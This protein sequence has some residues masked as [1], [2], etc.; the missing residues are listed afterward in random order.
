MKKLFALILA[1]TIIMQTISISVTAANCKAVTDTSATPDSATTCS[2]EAEIPGNFVIR[3]TKDLTLTYNDV[4]NINE[5][6][7]GYAIAQLYNDKVTSYKVKSGVST[8]SKDSAVFKQESDTEFIT[9]ATGNGRILLVKQATVSTAKKILNGQSN[10]K[11]NAIVLNITVNP[12]PL[13]IVYFAGQSNSEGS[14]SANLSYHPEDSVM[15]KLGEVYSTY[16]PSNDSRAQKITG[17]ENF[18]VCTKDKAQDYVTGSLNVLED[19]SISSKPLTYSLHSLTYSGNGKTGPD[20]GFAYKYNT[21]TGDKVW[22]VNAAWGGSSVKQ[23]VK[24][25]EAYNRAMAVYKEA[26]KTYNAEISAGHFTQSKRLCIWVQGEADKNESTS[27]YREKFTNASSNLISEL[28]LDKLGIIIVRSAIDKQYKNYRDNSLSAPRVVQTAMGNDKTLNKIHLVSRTHELWVTDDNVKNYFDSKYPSGTLN[29]P[30]RSNSTILH[31]P[32]TVAAIHYDIHFSQAGHN[33]NGIDAAENMYHILQNETHDVDITWLKEDGAFV[34][35]NAIDANLNIDFKLCARITPESQSKR[36]TISTD[37]NYLKYNKDTLTFTPIKSGTTYINVKNNNSVTID[38]LKVTINTYSL[39][40]PVIRKFENQSNSVKIS[41]DAVQGATHYRIYC[42]DGSKYVGLTTTTA[43]NYTHQGVESGKSYTYTVRCVDSK[44]NATSSYIKE[45]FTN[46]F[47][48]APVLTNASPA[49]DGV[50]VEWQAVNGACNYAVYRKGGESSS[51]TRIATTTDNFYVDTKAVSKTKYT[52]TVRCISKDSSTLLSGFDSDGKT[53]DYIATPI[54]NSFT[55]TYYGVT[56]Y[57]DKV[58]GAAA[59]RVF[60]KTADG[61]KGLAT[62]TTNSYFDSTATD[63][64]IY[65]YTVRCINT[66]T[67]TYTSAYSLEG[68]TV[69]TRLKTPVITS[70]ENT[71][72][73]VNIT[74]SKVEGAYKYRLFYHDGTQYRTLTT[75]SSTS[76]SHS[77]SKPS[78]SYTYTVR[79]VGADSSF[80]SDYVNKGFTN[81]YLAPPVIKA[82]KNSGNTITVS[83]HKRT[84]ASMYRVYRKSPSDTTWVRIADTKST[85]YIDRNVKNNT[86]YTYTVRCISADKSKFESSFDSKGKTLLHKSSSKQSPAQKTSTPKFR[87]K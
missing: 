4:V 1:L 9:T 68:Y 87:I 61:W 41:W 80:E 35:G 2:T 58:D 73:G 31:T 64:K 84:G 15:C 77:I 62:T 54:I 24:G 7:N 74:W 82:P 20:A 60:I 40:T 69:D 30:L 48:S 28:S 34:Y 5:Y 3:Q 86:S 21:L 32:D 19:L 56:L 13:T 65:T 76:F 43:T 71:R 33:E 85:Y 52:Y 51:Y 38:T 59:Y 8:N 44:N 50:K 25:G 63:R 39:P 49:V 22:V 46:V 66:E 36:F 27:F 14:C 83:W 37:T 12:A 10:T 47:L 18:T 42:H 72:T 23:W 79:C 29:Y 81:L 70:F 45:G 57:W 75:T 17:I 11:L 26:E 55:R 6:F 78:I 67:N 16:A 53:V